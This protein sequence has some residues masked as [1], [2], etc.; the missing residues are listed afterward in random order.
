M[1]ALAGG[2]KL[3]VGDGG[4]FGPPTPEQGRAAGAAKKLHWP[5][6]TYGRNSG[7]AGAAPIAFARIWGSLPLLNE[8]DGFGRRRCV[9]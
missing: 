3:G 8:V 4:G 2:A 7:G 6:K 1:A 5:L 9:P